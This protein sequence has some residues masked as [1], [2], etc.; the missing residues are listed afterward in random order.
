MARME[1]LMKDYDVIIAPSFGGDQL[2]ITNLTGH[3]CVVV[4]NGF[5]DGGSPTSISFIGALNGE[6]A[7][8]RVAA[9]YQEAT[10]WDEM[11]PPLFSQE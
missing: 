5:R 2:L 4:P 7:I 8:L 1:S 6:A 10:G 3:P 9:A 11:H